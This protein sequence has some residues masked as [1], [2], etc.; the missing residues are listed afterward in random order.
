MGEGVQGRDWV[1][2]TVLL[3][4]F[5]GGRVNERTGDLPEGVCQQ[6]QWLDSGVAGRGVEADGG[7]YDRLCVENGLWVATVSVWS[8]LCW[9]IGG[10]AHD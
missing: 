10:L 7:V 8:I 6:I 1:L 9:D 2:G 4:A 5:E 3:V